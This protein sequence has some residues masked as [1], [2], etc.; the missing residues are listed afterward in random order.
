[1]RQPLIKL[2][3]RDVSVNELTHKVVKLLLGSIAFW[4]GRQA[5]DITPDKIIAEGNKD[6][7]F[8]DGDLDHLS[9]S[10]LFEVIANEVREVSIKAQLIQR[11][12]CDAD[13]RASVLVL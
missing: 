8:V 9:P 13:P 6:Q 1:M 7:I 10:T 12:I 4:D 5:N 11:P 3:Y 2:A